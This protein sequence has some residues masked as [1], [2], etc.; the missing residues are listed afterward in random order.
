LDGIYKQ[1]S[2]V[3][4][5]GSVAGSVFNDTNSN[6]QLD[7]NEQGMPGWIIQLYSSATTP[8]T[9]TTDSTG[10]YTFPNL[11]D[12]TYTVRQ[13][14]QSGWKQTYPVTPKDYAV[15]LTNG[16]AVTDKIFGNSKGTRCSDGIDNDGNGFID[17]KD[18]TCHTDGNPDN[19]SSY[20]PN[21]DGERG[22][23]T[24]SDSKDNN[25]NGKKDGAD[26]ICHVDGDLTKPYDPDLPEGA[27]K[28]DLIISTASISYNNTTGSGF[29]CST[30]TGVIATVKNQGKSVVTSPFIVK[31]NDTSASVSAS[32]EVGASI[33]VFIPT[34]PSN[35]VQ[36]T[37]LADANNQIDESNESNN[38]FSQQIAVPTQPLECIPTP[39]PVTSAKASLALNLLLHGIGSSGDNANPTAN[40]LS[41]KN[42]LTKE[43]TAIVSLFDV[44]NN[45]VA[46][47][48]GKITYS[49]ASGSFQGIATTSATIPTGKYAIKV[50]TKN[51]L[52]RLVTGIQTLTSNQTTT[53]PAVEVVAGD[54]KEDNRL[55]I[56]DYNLLLD[57]YSDLEASTAC[58]PE[59]KL[60]TDF[61]DDGS[62]NQIDYNLFLREISTQ[63]GE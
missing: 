59:K 19:P 3:L 17:A 6:G 41:N 47:A 63:P 7:A 18:S 29:I 21:K 35:G 44:N 62:V 58:S 61:N 37:I 10:S 38:Q 52:T 2:E 4:A 31:A 34:S 36:T 56:M 39:T 48:E 20:D 22:S 42:P 15:S 57:C 28:P 11:C 26:P 1:I 51:H 30:G 13:V 25:G 45:L 50:R 24:C 16:N 60:T 27:N 53:L 54:A 32:I 23:N 55:D 40:S 49:S 8:Q 12:D 33:N 14:L 43:R 46:T 5:K 9:I